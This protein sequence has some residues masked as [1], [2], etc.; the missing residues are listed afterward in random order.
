MQVS[1]TAIRGPD[2]SSSPVTI[3]PE[4]YSKIL[5]QIERIERAM[6][7][8][9]A[10]LGISP[11][12]L[13]SIALSAKVAQQKATLHALFGHDEYPIREC[14]LVQDSSHLVKKLMK[15][16]RQISFQEICL[17]FSANPMKSQ[18]DQ[19]IMEIM[20]GKKDFPVCTCETTSGALETPYAFAA[21]NSP[22][23]LMQDS[24]IAFQLPLNTLEGTRTA[25]CFAVFDG[26]G[27]WNVFA[28]EFCKR[29]I[30]NSLTHCMT[31][32]N[33]DGSDVSIVNGI[34]MTFVHLDEAFKEHMKSYPNTLAG[35]TACLVLIVQGKI[36]SAGAG[37]SRAVLS[38]NNESSV[39]QLTYD[40][41]AKYPQTHET[42][43]KRGGMIRLCK[44]GPLDFRVNGTLNMTRAI[45]DG[46]LRSQDGQKVI[47]PRPKVTIIPLS[48]LPPGTTPFVIIGSDGLFDA[49]SNE[50]L[51]RFTLWMQ[52]TNIPLKSCADV[53]VTVTREAGSM[54]DITAGIISL[55]KYTPK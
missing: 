54:D 12:S 20:K 53:L 47:S 14:K 51:V 19:L 18:F 31:H 46:R 37:D 25:D 17:P 41:N 42:V 10:Q 5:E 45:G 36:Y 13:S 48:L 23:H 55:A 30:T 38:H 39:L 49:A 6:T 3:S 7:R 50:A 22:Y 11:L 21:L 26:H 35:T 33:Q 24:S 34:I 28:S 52:Q 27:A 9:E 15:A 43:L 4:Q 32:L 1:P 44:G 16:D 8:I 29:N 40:W 2:S